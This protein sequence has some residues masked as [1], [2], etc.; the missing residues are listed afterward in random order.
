MQNKQS[1]IKRE[2][3]RFTLY[4][5][6]DPFLEKGLPSNV[7]A[8]RSILGAILLDNAVC[9][10]AI[11]LLQRDMF[12]LDSHRRI[13]DKMVSLRN[14]DRPI[15]LIT[16]TDE[17]RKAGEF[18]QVGGAVYISSL[19]D[20]V[21]RTD[22]IEPYAK[23]VIGRWF[24]R[25]MITISN[26]IIA[27]CFD[28]EEPEEVL[29]SAEA[30]YFELGAFKDSKGPEHVGVIGQRVLEQVEARQGQ[31]HEVIGLASRFT[32][33]DSLLLG[34]QP[35]LYLLCGRPS[36]GKTALATSI[37]EQIAYKGDYVIDFSLEM[38]AEKRVWRMLASM[39]RV[40]SNRLR[41]G[42]LNRE[43]WSRLSDAFRRMNDMALYVDDSPGLTW[44]QI[45]AKARRFKA[46]LGLS[47]IVIDYA[48]L[49]GT[50]KQHP[51]ENS[52]GSEK[53]KG[54]VTTWK[55]LNV[56]V[57]ALQQLNRNCE[58]R[59]DKRPKCSDIRNSGSWEQ[60]ADVVMFV[61]NESKYFL[62]DENA[63]IVEVIVDK[64]RD[65]A[66]GT[67]N[68]AYIKEFTRFENLWR[69]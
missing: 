62:T 11:E 3:S 24:L 38:S 1:L 16:L 33:L 37:E 19:I 63:G 23:I 41:L 57:L 36:H 14:Q 8:E 42:Y 34:F 54:L 49:M 26:T 13:F 10:Q 61:Y 9:D 47:M 48:D 44:T 27:R 35:G 69:D 28:E 51:N 5:Q 67:V 6:S 59:S 2:D 4:K 45:H 40:D 53:S 56:P 46:Q 7:E 68:L 12:F 20:G 30:A 64:N 39:A 18:E 15:D 17:L 31:S 66:T 58:T 25:R 43:E 52:E 29:S 22:T 21:P 60:D 32:D 50:V 65:G 55:D